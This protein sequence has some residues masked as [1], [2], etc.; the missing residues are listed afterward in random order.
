MG[1]IGAAGGTEEEGRSGRRGDEDGRASAI[2]EHTNEG[3]DPSPVAYFRLRSCPPWGTE[4]I[5]AH[6]SEV[7]KGDSQ[8]PWVDES[9]QHTASGTVRSLV[10]L[11]ESDRPS[12]R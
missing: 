11:F 10:Q 3:N 1:R 4:W 7:T 9:S 8:K 6:A 2:S 5:D 12:R